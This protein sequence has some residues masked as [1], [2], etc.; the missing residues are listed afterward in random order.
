[1]KKKIV[2]FSGNR[3]EYSLQLPIIRAVNKRSDLEYF[4]IVSGTH[5]KDTYGSTIEEI[6][7]DGLKIGEIIDIGN[8]EKDP[9]SAAISMGTAIIKITKI[10]KKIKPDIFCIYGDR[11]ETFAAAAASSQNNIIT[12]HVEGGDLTEGGTHDDNLRHAITKISHIHFAT[13]NE[14]YKRILTLGEE[15]WRVH[16]AGYPAIDLIKKNEYSK[17]S[18]L[19]KEFNINF[20]RPLI[21]FTQHPISNNFN[22]V[23]N[24]LLSSL[25]AIQKFVDAYEAHCIITFPNNDAGGNIIVDSIEKFALGKS[26]ITLVKSL[27]RKRYWGFLNLAKNQ[28]YNIV[29]MG[30]SSSGIKE[31]PAFCCPTINIGSRQDGRMQGK[32]VINCPYDEDKIFKALE[33]TIFDKKFREICKH[34]KNPY[35]IGNAA[36]KIAKIL[37]S[38]NLDKKILTKRMSS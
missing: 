25:N 18:N 30:N 3:A 22:E 15:K 23:D 8:N 10:I 11:Y 37:S 24:Q 34:A 13:N 29:C 32:N 28:N 6:K 17:I 35:G 20:K 4:L 27:G 2:F 12:A 38:L 26:N 33:K 16:L 19:K 7:S 5:V 21:I 31:T 14:S 9:Y 1:M 36:N